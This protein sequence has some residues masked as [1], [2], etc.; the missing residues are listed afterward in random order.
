MRI[1]VFAF[2]YPPHIGASGRLV[3]EMI[4]YLEKAHRVQIV[5]V[6]LAIKW[7]KRYEHGTLQPQRVP[8][9]PLPAP[10][11]AIAVLPLFIY[12]SIRKAKDTDIIVAQHHSFH[13]ASAAAMIAGKL[14][15]KPVVVRSEDVM[16]PMGIG[17]PVVI[18]IIGYL[19]ELLGTKAD[20]FTVVC[21]EQRKALVTRFK[22]APENIEIHPNFASSKSYVA[23]GPTDYSHSSPI[24]VFV[25]RLTKE[26]GLDLLLKAI[27]MV[28]PRYP[29]LKVVLIGD[30]P[31]LPY[32]RSLAAS[33]SI[34]RNVLFA[35]VCSREQVS[36]WLDRAFVGIG[37]LMPTRT[38]PRKILEYS[39]S[40]VAMLVGDDSVTSDFA[41]PGENCVSVF[42][43]PPE[44]A[45]GLIQL[46][47]D[48]QFR[49]KLTIMAREK[50]REFE[51]ERVCS[52]F[53]SLLK[54]AA[55]RTTVSSA[56]RT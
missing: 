1:L 19:T 2:Y 34:E 56:R 16:R 51:L 13:F 21:S 33:L 42:P 29:D 55:A 8:S 18:R 53:E 52:T 25:G 31:E 3:Q 38:L 10:V 35:G 32:L 26:Y 41:A 4:S 45:R 7:L 43:N 6:N 17:V 37:P 54:R 46:I 24:I 23:R 48:P 50:A 11:A 27:P 14:L 20:M 9:L 22:K 49:T 47:A 15:R 5:T 30:G 12:W 40:S 28:V 39:F 44:I 36:E